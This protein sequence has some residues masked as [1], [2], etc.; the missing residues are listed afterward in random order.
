MF[1][2]GGEYLILVFQDNGMILVEFKFFGVSFQ[3]VLCV[4][5]G[6][7]I[8]LE[9]NIEVLVLDFING[10][11]NGIIIIQVISMCKVLIM[12]EMCDGESFVIVG[13]LCEDF[14]DVIS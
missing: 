5:D 7:L 1:Y 13:L 2:V 6:D 11:I 12:V 3:F 8:N 4:V 9:L 10:F 14:Q